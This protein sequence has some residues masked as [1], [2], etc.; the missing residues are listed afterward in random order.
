M[1]PNEA[2]EITARAAQWQAAAA[3]AVLIVTGVL[4]VI[5]FFA[6]R[7]AD[8]QARAA[9]RALDEMK[10]QRDQMELQREEMARQRDEMRRQTLLAALP[11]LRVYPPEGLIGDEL[12]L[13]TDLRITNAGSVPALGVR[14]EFRAID[15]AE[16]VGFHVF[17]RGRLSMVV[18]GEIG[19]L[20]VDSHELWDTHMDSEKVQ[21]LQAAGEPP[22]FYHTDRLLLS[23]SFRGP[24]GAVVEQDYR[25]MPNAPNATPA[26]QVRRLQRVKITPDPSEPGEELSVDLATS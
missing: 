13:V 16:A 4:A 11:F 18:P 20:R 14:V 3:I 24:L 17:A 19:Y 12:R 7:A 21:A 2:L 25:W 23:F 1:D 9:S 15:P 5:A 10:L 8:D 6:W 22:G 26:E